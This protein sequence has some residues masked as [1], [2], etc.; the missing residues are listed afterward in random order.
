MLLKPLPPESLGLVSQSEE[1]L[2]G[3]LSEESSE[4]LV[5]GSQGLPVSVSEGVTLCLSSSLSLRGGGVELQEQEQ[6]ITHWL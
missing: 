6:N 5:R 1:V 3:S 4:V 2:I